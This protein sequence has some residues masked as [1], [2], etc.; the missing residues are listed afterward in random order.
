MLNLQHV[1]TEQRAYIPRTLSRSVGVLSLSLIGTVTRKTTAVPMTLTED[2]SVNYYAIRVTLPEI[3]E[4]EY[5][6]TLSD[7]EGTL[8]QGL[9]IIGE[10]EYAVKEH[11]ARTEYKQ[12]NG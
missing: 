8:S 11:N 2:Q 7:E 10:R 1:R 3:E 12:Y 6:Y 9:A 4:G 5:E